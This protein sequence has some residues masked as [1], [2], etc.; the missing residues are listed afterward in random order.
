MEKNTRKY[1]LLRTVGRFF[2]L[3][4]KSFKT[5]YLTLF[6]AVIITALALVFYTVSHYLTDVNYIKSTGLAGILLIFFV[7]SCYLFD[8]TSFFLRYF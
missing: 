3:V 2:S 5:W 6:Y 8:C 4:F 7:I 1:T